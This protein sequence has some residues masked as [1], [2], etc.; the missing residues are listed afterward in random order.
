MDKFTN[1]KKIL[2]SVATGI[3]TVD[4]DW[5]ITFF[6]NEAEKITGFTKA[7]AIGHKC[8]EIFRTD[9][10]FS[11]C[12]L[13]N[14]IKTKMK[15]VNVR[16]K[17]LN[18]NN[19][20]VHVDI[21]ASILEDSQGRFMG[22]VESFID[23]SARVT[24]E[25]KIEESYIC[26]D[27]IGKDKKIVGLFDIISVV[28]PTNANV[29]ILGETG[30]GKDLFARAVHNESHR[31]KGP[32]IKVNCPA[33]PDNLLESELFGYTRG[34]FTDAK[35]SKHGRFKMADG[36]TIFLDEIGD[37]SIDLQAKLF[38]VLDENEF[39]PLGAT[40]PIK[41][42]VRVIAST[43]K[44]LFKMVQAGKFREDLYYRLKVVELNIPHLR[45][46]C[47]DVPLLI[48]YFLANQ[49]RILKKKR[50]SISPDAM[51]ILTAYS[52]PGNVRELKHIIEHST[53][54][55]QKQT[56]EIGDLP[57]YLLKK[58]ATSSREAKPEDI[59][60]ISD[61]IFKKEKEIISDTLTAHG[62]SRHETAKV[63]NMN[64]STLW[65]KMKR[66]GLLPPR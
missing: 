32:F 54:L 26:Y 52:Y 21:T 50:Y 29:L 31:K 53:I 11:G 17:I 13:K 27:V 42:D 66:H 33:L 36:G 18:K 58:S 49:A 6:N 15:I 3:F 43:N 20:K 9:I 30:S 12:Y 46:R 55:C 25:K 62:W 56:I 45:E 60:S 5:N 8:Y 63:L 22:G 16:N 4:A 19:R 28:A 41:V 47:S 61:S 14:A 7:E 34:A 40:T 1:Y 59:F 44:D 48:D 51:K 65:R 39:Y 37:L 35:Q 10:C 64:R 57:E 23:D 2:N 38:Q 24:L